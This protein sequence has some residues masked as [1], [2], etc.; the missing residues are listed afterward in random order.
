M[1]TTLAVGDL[2][3][4]R[5]G[6][7]E[8]ARDLIRLLRENPG[9]RLAIA[10]DL[11]DLSADFPGEAPLVALGHALEASPLVPALGE[12]VDRGGELWWVAGNHDAPVG[13]P[14]ARALV[15]NALRIGGAARER[16]RVSPWFLRE[17]GLHLEHGHLYDPDNALSHPL[18]PCVRSL[19]VHFV[20]EFIAPTGAF[21]YLNNNDAT[22]LKLFVSAFTWYG[23]RGPYVVYRYFRTAFRAL[24][25]SGLFFDDTHEIA[26]GTERERPFAEDVGAEAELLEALRAHASTPTLKS[27]PDTFRRLYLDRVAATVALTAGAV[28]AATNHKKAAAV[29]AGAGALV[30]GTSWA[31]G[32]DRYGGAV[33]ERLERAGVAIAESTDTELVVFGHAHSEVASGRYANTAS[34]A[35]PKGAPGRPYLWFTDPK[36]PARRYLAPPP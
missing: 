24:A 32:H 23:R 2:H 21:R 6:S 10:G 9:C 5:D 27:F 36:A 25:R 3:L 33:S 8:V 30:M 34:F 12:H 11:F 16:I 35:F 4:V 29:V 28:L 1:P 7:G 15:E 19:G 22:P 17:G 14:A 20:E 26:V 13:E 18:Y 31:L